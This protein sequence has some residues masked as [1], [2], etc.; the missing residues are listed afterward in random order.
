MAVNLNT[1]T[2]ISTQSY[3]K[4]ISNWLWKHEDEGSKAKKWIW[5]ALVRILDETRKNRKASLS[6]RRKCFS[7][8]N[9]LFLIF[10]RKMK[11]SW[12]R[13]WTFLSDIP[14]RRELYTTGKSIENNCN[15]NFPRSIIT[16][17]RKLTSMSTQKRLIKLGPTS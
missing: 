13:H 16:S 15:W 10:L 7:F 5:V 14:M 1:H 9:Y 4:P 6:C 3:M 2:Y 12:H 8:V 17:F 11:I